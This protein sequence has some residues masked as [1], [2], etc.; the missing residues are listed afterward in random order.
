MSSH[1]VSGSP[2]TP[3]S[4]RNSRKTSSSPST[5]STPKSPKRKSRNSRNSSNLESSST[6]R[7]KKKSSRSPSTRS[8]SSIS[9]FSNEEFSNENPVIPEWWDSFLTKLRNIIKLMDKIGHNYVIAGSSANALLTYYFRPDLLSKLPEPNDGDFI[10]IP[11]KFSSLTSFLEIGLTKI[12][13]YET[14]NNF[15]NSSTFDN[16]RTSQDEFD[17]ID[18]NLEGHI[19]YIIVD[20]FKIIDPEELND[21]YIDN[22]RENNNKKR[23][24]LSQVLESKKIELYEKQ[25]FT[26][27]NSN[28][29]RRPGLTKPSKLSF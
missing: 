3:S 21:R 27:K 17:S 16:E 11:D 15:E 7:T 23:E 10:V 4:K 12:G 18:I 9:S 1:S 26:K 8:H 5:P 29:R 2:S 22:W 24:I 13:T 25:K 28:N 14:Q 20:G 6:K 19:S